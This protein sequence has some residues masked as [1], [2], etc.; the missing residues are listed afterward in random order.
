MLHT[1][2]HTLLFKPPNL[3]PHLPLPG[4]PYYLP[5]PWASFELGSFSGVGGFWWLVAL[6]ALL[7]GW[8]LLEALQHLQVLAVLVAG[9][10]L[11]THYPLKYPGRLTSCLAILWSSSLYSAEKRK[12]P[13]VTTVRAMDTL[14]V[15]SKLTYAVTSELA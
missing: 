6:V 7:P 10:A 11:I 1:L 3:L 14:V 12:K 5:A 13:D 4:G 8:L 9:H 15:F 2:C